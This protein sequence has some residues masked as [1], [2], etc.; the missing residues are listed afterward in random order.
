MSCVALWYHPLVGSGAAWALPAVRWPGVRWRPDLFRPLQYASSRAQL[1][2]VGESRP[3]HWTGATKL[4]SGFS[5]LSHLLGGDAT[6][7]LADSRGYVDCCVLGCWDMGRG[8]ARAALR[9]SHSCSTS[10][11]PF[12]PFS[13]SFVRWTLHPPGGL[14]KAVDRQPAGRP[15]P[16]TSGHAGKW[17][18][19][20]A[21]RWLGPRHRP[22][23][24]TAFRF[25]PRAV[26]VT[27]W[28]CAWK[29]VC[30]ALHARVRGVR[31][32]TAAPCAR[33]ARRSRLTVSPSGHPILHCIA[34]GV[35]AAS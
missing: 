6:Q 1:A 4:R 11:S 32:R 18:G 9:D 17:Y 28:L 7:D 29:L 15:P 22:P 21:R 19:Y 25:T 27:H 8:V 12:S 5:V 34:L 13:R 31:C 10:C 33:C 35:H 30:R 16:A 3:G 23:P 24:R 26:Y 20:E 2:S 14:R